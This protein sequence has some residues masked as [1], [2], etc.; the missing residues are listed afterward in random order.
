MLAHGYGEGTNPAAISNTPEMKAAGVGRAHWVTWAFPPHSPSHLASSSKEPSPVAPWFRESSHS[1]SHPLLNSLHIPVPASL[2]SLAVSVLITHTPLTTRAP[3]QEL[4]W[5][6]PTSCLPGQGETS[7]QD[8][9]SCPEQTDTHTD[10]PRGHVA[11]PLLMHLGR[12]WSHQT[13]QAPSLA[14]LSQSGH[15]VPATV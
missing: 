6:I 5:I 2:S 10:H 8:V 4:L 15:S 3:L 14:G 1:T 12:W 13:L 7:G 11:S 9:S